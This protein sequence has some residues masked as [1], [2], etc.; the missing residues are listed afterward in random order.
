LARLAEKIPSLNP[1]NQKQFIFMK[2]H[3]FI[4]TLAIFAV[5]LSPVYSQFGPMAGGAQLGGGM[6]KLFGDNKSFSA[7]LEVQT[8]DQSGTAMTFPGKL[9]FDAGN[10]RFEMNMAEMK[11]GSF[12]PSALTQMKSMGLDRM[13][14]ISLS[15]KKSVF[16]IY[17]NVQSYVE[18]TSDPAAAATNN[19]TT[20][21]TTKLGEETVAGHP[22]VKNKEV[23]TDKQGGK[24]EFT[25]WNATDLKN[26]PIQIQM[27]VQGNPITLSYSDLNFSKPDASLFAPPTGFTRYDNMQTMMQTVMMKRLGGGMARPPGQ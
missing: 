6:D 3:I 23:V 4:L 11:G 14:S 22:C 21:E 5:G 13:V 9:T 20:I 19:D 15:D 24:Q 10:S 26:F 25:V 12:P 8:K 2:K 18:M 1:Q 17:P 27:T 16:V 7:T